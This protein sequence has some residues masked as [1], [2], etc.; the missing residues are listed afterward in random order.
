MKS[1]I[2]IWMFPAMLLLAACN[3]SPDTAAK[4][5]D[6][7]S[8]ST[9]TASKQSSSRL[10]S[11]LRLESIGS[12]KEFLERSAGQSI[13]ETEDKSKYMVDGCPVAFTLNGKTVTSIDVTLAKGCHFDMAGILGQPSPVPVDDSFTFA[14]FEKMAGEAQYHSPCIDMCGNAF[15][16]YVDAIVPG[17]HAN[18]FNDVVARAVF[19]EDDAVDASLHWSEQLKAVAGEDFVV[20]AKFNC[21]ASHDDIPR[22]LFAKVKVQEIIFGTPASDQNCQ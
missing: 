10:S 4:T 16:P 17:F 9:P 11:L 8:G 1:V 3:R 20:D 15:D 19:V 2:R 13:A 18:G 5:S 7:T 14:Q 21:D 22:R 12:T 6:N